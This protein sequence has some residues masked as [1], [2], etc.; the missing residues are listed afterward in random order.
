[1]SI[2]TCNKATHLAMNVRAFARQQLL[3]DD[4]IEE[5]TIAFEDTL[6]EDY[7]RKSQVLGKRRRSD[8]DQDGDDA[9]K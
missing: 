1:M 6:M 5:L 9:F 8:G 3:S 4:A 7:I 2:E